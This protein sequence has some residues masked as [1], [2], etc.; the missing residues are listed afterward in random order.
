MTSHKCPF[1]GWSVCHNFLKGKLHFYVSIGTLVPYLDP[2]LLHG[3][4]DGESVGV[5]GAGTLKGL[6]LDTVVGVRQPRVHPVL[7][8]HTHTDH[9]PETWVYNYTSEIYHI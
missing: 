5:D 1:V 4:E 8:F 2:N 6:L 3:G 9:V 7:L